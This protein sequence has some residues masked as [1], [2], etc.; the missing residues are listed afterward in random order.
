MEDND[1]DSVLQ[2]I[3]CILMDL[4]IE[5]FAT[6]SRLRGTHSPESDLDIVVISQDSD[7]SINEL[8]KRIKSKL[9][10]DYSI[11]IEQYSLSELVKGLRIGDPLI[12]TLFKDFRSLNIS[13][14]TIR[15]LTKTIPN[16]PPEDSINHIENA[17]LSN[18]TQAT[19][20]IINA[21][22]YEGQLI[23]VQNNELPA[24]PHQLATKLKKYDENKSEIVKRSIEL[25]KEVENIETPPDRFFYHSIKLYIELNK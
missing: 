11:D 1:L 20:H 19:M 8:R 13:E 5:A 12:I 10:V 15:I 17:R 14:E 16:N 6:G 22:F 9:D 25:K 4:D 21:I 23:L 7:A 2:E 18:I 3:S 24:P